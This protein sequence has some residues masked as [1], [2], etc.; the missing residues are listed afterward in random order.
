MSRCM[1]KPCRT[2][3]G[4]KA[5]RIAP[6][7]ADRS[8]TSASC[9]SGFG[10]AVRSTML[11]L[12][13]LLSVASFSSVSAD[14]VRTLPRSRCSSHRYS[15]PKVTHFETACLQAIVQQTVYDP[16]KVDW[17]AV[18]EACKMIGASCSCCS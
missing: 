13:L 10:R 5:A 2:V 8:G 14:N 16:S 11:C 12:I 18:V 1:W 7:V 6:M 3:A 9:L 17:K 4:S 15:R